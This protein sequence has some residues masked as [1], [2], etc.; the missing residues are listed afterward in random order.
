MARA[1]YR[2]AMWRGATS[3]VWSG[4]GLL[5]RRGVSGSLVRGS[6]LSGGTSGYEKAMS[7]SMHAVLSRRT[8]RL[9]LLA[10]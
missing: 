9:R 6:Q 4:G 10:P 5:V 7:R 8:F 1:E 3:E 2:A